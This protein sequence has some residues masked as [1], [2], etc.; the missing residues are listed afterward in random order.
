MCLPAVR[1]LG[2]IGPDA[3][4]AV[5]V[6]SDLYEH[7]SGG[8]KYVLQN[9]IVAALCSIGPKTPSALALLME[10][11]KNGHMEA[12]WALWR[13]DPR[14]TQLAIDVALSQLDPTGNRSRRRMG[15]HRGA[16]P[17]RGPRVAPD[18][19]RIWRGDEQYAIALLG[20]IG[21]QAETA[22]PFL[23]EA[24]QSHPPESIA[25]NAAWALWRIDTEQKARA[26]PVFQALRGSANSGRNSELNWSAVG[27]L[28]QIAPEMR[29]ELRPTLFAMLDEWKTAP[30]ARRASTEMKTLLP[31]LTE[32]ANDDNDPEL[33]SWAVMVI[34]RL[35]RASF[36]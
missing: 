12:A 1:T 20:E 13:S 25:F 14:Y 26:I 18:G 32:I 30:A 23:E 9:A 31:A 5:P 3:A 27:A 29:D 17:G 35:N 10:L 19:H 4:A 11:A 21:P 36:Y 2:V 33:R 34:R 15:D 16:G 8:D 7:S 28:W 22:V 24:L 6:L